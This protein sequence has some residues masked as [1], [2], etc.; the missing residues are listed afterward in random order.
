LSGRFIPKLASIYD[1]PFAVP[2]MP[3]HLVTMLQRFSVTVYQEIGRG[4]AMP[5]LGALKQPAFILSP[6]QPRSTTAGRTGGERQVKRIIVK[7]GNGLSFQKQKHTIVSR[8][9]C[10]TSRRPRHRDRPR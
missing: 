1:E 3:M 4:I 5:F 8:L 6:S 9:A 7:A 2:Q 10:R